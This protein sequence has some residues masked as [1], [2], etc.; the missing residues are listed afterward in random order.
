[1]PLSEDW[2][3]LPELAACLADLSLR[4]LISLIAWLN[5]QPPDCRQETRLCEWQVVEIIAKSITKAVNLIG[6][7]FL[8]HTA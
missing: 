7:P 6:R 5:E 2:P 1:M 8:E 4:D 3:F